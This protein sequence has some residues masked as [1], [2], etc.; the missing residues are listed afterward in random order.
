MPVTS[1]QA[2]C[3]ERAERR[4][5]LGFDKRSLAMQTG[6]AEQYPTCLLV[7]PLSRPAV[8]L[9]GFPHQVSRCPK[10]PLLTTFPLSEGY[11]TCT[12]TA[13][14]RFAPGCR[15]VPER[16]RLHLDLAEVEPQT[17]AFAGCH[18]RRPARSTPAG[19]RQPRQRSVDCATDQQWGK[20]F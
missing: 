11:L 15:A 18:I 4:R 14:P 7:V 9:V 13:H 5:E 19:S 10:G 12:E 2:C 17:R 3:D 20:E 6:L 8:V 16:R 1:L